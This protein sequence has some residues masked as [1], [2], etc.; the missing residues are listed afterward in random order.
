MGSGSQFNNHFLSAMALFAF[1]TA[2]PVL[3]HA[4]NWQ[5][6]APAVSPSAR[7]YCAMAYD[8]AS[9]KIVVFGGQG[10]SGNLNDT[11]TF[12][13]TTWAQVSTSSAPPVRNGA[14]MGYDRPTKKVI[15]FGGFNGKQY[16][17]D[18]WVWDGRASTWTQATMPSPPPSA[19]GAMLFSDPVT[20]KATMFGGYNATKVIPVSSFTWQWT[21]T[22]WKKLSPS[23]VP[24]PRGWGIAD[25]DPLHHN[26][27]LTGGTGD[28]IRTDNTWTWDGT[29]WTSVPPA[30]QA[31]AMI[32]AG[33][34]FDPALQEVVV[35][36]GVAETWTWNGTTWAQLSPTN[37]PSARSGVGMAYDHTTRQTILF[38]GQLANGPMTN[39]TWEFV[40]P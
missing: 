12:D 37:S 32:G 33:Y 10:S 39:E 29:N 3:I 23:T 9:K 31:E 40:A 28:T 19:T 30:V 5:Q 13:G 35:F 6:L 36:G 24:I 18:T 20:G 17:Q 27:V 15:L 34:A 16:L 25:L 11:W 4:S 22:A 38:G 26:V 8:P 7:S 2:Q 1:A 21:G 14:T